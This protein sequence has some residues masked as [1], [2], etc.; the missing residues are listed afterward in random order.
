LIKEG[1]EVMKLIKCTLV[2]LILIGERR[3]EMN[4]AKKM[5][6]FL[7]GITLIVGLTSLESVGAEKKYPAKPIRHVVCYP[8]GGD[9]DLT[10]RVWANFVEKVLGQPVTVINKVGGGGVSGTTFAA[11]AKPDGY[12]LMQAA[13]GANIVSP[14]VAKTEYNLDSFV[15][16]AR[17][18]AS[19]GGLAV[20]VDSPW[21]TMEEFVRDAKKNP[22]K[23][24]LGSCGAISSNTLFTR[25]WAMQAGIELKFVHHQGCAPA[26]TALLGRHVDICFLYSQ[27]FV[28]Q[29]K[30]GKLRALAVAAPL[31][32][33]PGV[34]TFNKLGYEGSYT[35]FS[36]I[37]APK[38]T[39]ASAI[40]TLAAATAKVMK[41]P[42]FVQA[43]KNIKARPA[44]LGPEEFQ[45]DMKQQYED[46]GKVIDAMGL[47]PK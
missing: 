33:L 13:S 28:P 15:G 44:F 22:G 2:K 47:R 4:S 5:F 46:L 36:G 27:S 9:T 38:G 3:S 41:D 19:P 23:L 31:E 39:P 34:P 11:K 17:L 40:K 18:T 30:A 12:T 21:K 24:N 7:L 26:T 32:G 45:K 29:V 1:E 14:Q 43:L 25:Q 20:H 6:I 35:G 8:P 37:L 16:V 10:A 42:E